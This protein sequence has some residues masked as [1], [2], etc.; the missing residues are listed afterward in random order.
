M[1]AA[2]IP[3]VRDR[4]TWLLYLMLAYGTYMVSTMGPLMPFLAADLSLSYTERGLHT[5]AFAIGG[6]IAGVT[7]D[8][9]ARRFGRPR[10]FWFSGGGL[11]AG[12]LLLI[13]LRT[14]VLT[15]SAAFVMGLLGTLMFV[16]VQ[17]SLADYHGDRR[18]IAISE[19]NVGA[20][21]AGMLAPLL[22]SQ[23]EGLSL[24]WRLALLLG[25]GAWAV[26][27]VFGRK[28]AI[29][30]APRTPVVHTGSKRLP[31]L[32]WLFWG[33]MFLGVAVEWSVGFWTAEYFERG[34]GLDRVSAAGVLT[35]FWMAIIIGRV[36]GS[37][38]SRRYR[39]TILL[40]GAASLAAAAFPIMLLAREPAIATGALF[41]TGLG[42][43]NFFPMSLA[44]AINAAAF[45]TNAASARIALANGLA[46]LIAPQVL[47]SIADQLGIAP[48]Y[49]V[50]GGMLVVLVALAVFANWAQRRSSQR[51]VVA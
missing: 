39:P 47:G 7:A 8:R 41:V 9:I 22:I 24:G 16:T 49:A 2:A 12:A 27:A 15:I 36:A 10:L 19:S 13:L 38:L 50:I 29:P 44:S 46:I 31:R 5:S 48:A 43:A 28:I 26:M 30:S 51:L 35:F 18:S 40:I 33:T 37:F 3:F 4:L 32:F 25:I 17:A 45:N 14:P 6:I 21:V 1:T 34:I 11:A 20:A 42:V 23:A